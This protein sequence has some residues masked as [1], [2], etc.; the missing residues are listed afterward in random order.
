MRLTHYFTAAFLLCILLTATVV[1]GQ[2]AYITV[3][4]KKTGEPVAFAHVCF[5]PLSADA[6]FY[7]LTGMDGRAENSAREECRIA[8]SCVGYQTLFDTLQPGISKMYRL[9]PSILNMEEVVVTAQ[10]TPER[11][12]KSIYRVDVI[13]SMTIEQRGAINLTD[14]LKDEVS[15]NVSQRGVLGTSLSIQ[16]LSGENVK[17]LQDG[18]PMIG[19]MN[20]NFDLDQINLNNVDHIEIIEGPMSVIYGSNALAGVINLI[21]RENKGALL[22]ARLN[23]YGETTGDLNFD[24]SVSVSVKKHGFSA[25]GGRNFFPGMSTPLDS[26]RAQTYKP[27]RQYFFEGSYTFSTERLKFK[28]AGDY[29]NELLA[30]KGNLQP[31]YFE[32]AFDAWFTT[33]RYTL[34][35]D[36]SARLFKSHFLNAL[37]SWSGYTRTKETFLKDLTTLE[38]VRTIDP[39]QQDT[40][41]IRALNGRAT[42]AKNDLSKQF[43]YQLGADLNVEWGSGKRI[44]DTEQQIGDYAAFLSVR[45]DPW[46]TLSL[47]P[48]VRFIYNTKY[49]AP[50]VYALSIKWEVLNGFSVRASYSHGFRAP[51]IK[52]LY[53]NFVDINHSI[54]GNPDLKAETSNNFNLGF[55]FLKEYTSS[56]FNID[57][58][59]FY[60]AMK[61][62]IT[63]AQAEGIRYTYIN[64]D[65]YRT[66]GGQISATAS[67]YPSLK[68]QAGLS[69]TGV[70]IITGEKSVTGGFVF[71]TDITA[72]ASWRFQKPELTLALQYKYTG[73][74]P[75]SSLQDSTEVEYIGAYN[76]LDFTATKGF[77]KN[78]IRL[79]G[80]VKNIFNV[81]VVDATGVSGGVHGGGGVT[82]GS[83]PVGYGRSWFLRLSINFNKYQ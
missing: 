27:R 55:Q 56:A 46:K 42:F 61:N 7:M 22:N 32:T 47:Q 52:E 14:L 34:R 58:A 17:F 71:S 81:M 70:N 68:I 80:G 10:Y 59:G 62:I 44:L 1:C 83:M 26:G 15:M 74:K 30:D 23:L 48:G 77:W 20:G 63:L 6:P 9:S 79:S 25:G 8:I 28:L 66:T 41:G 31:P 18:V 49:R 40:T 39:E 45:Y 13:N 64:L 4:D 19:R 37:L 21:S 65:D 16:G 43:N 5:E 35:A 50:L 82:G 24:G 11:A 73:K 57:L 3:S 72:S 54:T 53:L 33:I 51:T 67:F 60:N 78:R 76:N 2:K 12:D 38:E 29:F 75:I 69:E 36:V